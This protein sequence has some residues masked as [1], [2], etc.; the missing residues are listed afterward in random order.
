M[1]RQLHKEAKAKKLT[2][3]IHPMLAQLSDLEAF[4]DPDWMFEIKWDGYR[5]IAEVSG[6]EVKV[7]SRNGQLFT[8]TYSAVS[9]ALRTLNVVAVLDGE[10]VVYDEHG[11][12]A[13]RTCKTTMRLRGAE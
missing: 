13:F 2:A 9:D 12:R 7:Y 5:A 3:F 4:N 6:S 1:P 11:N 10:I 8:T